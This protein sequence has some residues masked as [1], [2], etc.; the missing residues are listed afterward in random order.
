MRVSNLVSNSV[1]V[2]KFACANPVVKNP[3]AKLLNSRVVNHD[4]DQWI[5]FQF[6]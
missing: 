3:A 1:P 5:S 2:T 4:Y 6:H